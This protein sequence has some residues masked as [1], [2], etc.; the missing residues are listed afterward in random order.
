MKPAWPTSLAV[1]EG[2]VGAL[3]SRWMSAIM[4]LT[5]A[6]VTATIGLANAT[7][8]S[9][10]A[11]AER[12]WIDAGGYVFVVEPS[13]DSD[14]ALDV[15]ACERLSSV[16]GVGGSFAVTLTDLAAS[17]SH[18]PGSTASVARVSPGI[19]QFFDVKPEA[20]GADVIVTPGVNGQTAMVAG[21]S[22]VMTI[23]AFDGTRARQSVLAS[24][25]AID[26]PILAESI[27]GAYLIG[28]LLRGEADQCYVATDAAH[29][30]TVR[31]YI[32]SALGAQGPALVRPRLSENTYGVDFATAY[33]TRPLGWAWCVGALALLTPWALLRYSRRTA[34][35]VYATFGVHARARLTMQ[36]TEWTVV[37]GV[38]AAWGWAIATTFAVGLGADIGIALQQ[39]TLQAAAAWCAASVG[40]VIIGLLPVGTLLDVLKERT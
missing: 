7:D 16:D 30:E 25:T 4:V 12:E 31:T 18:A 32:A 35:A 13:P 10:L 5:T 28:D 17:P 3:T 9:A 15:T 40:A 2:F 20:A 39:I 23:E 1:R 38:G 11:A 29:V 6:G 36:M 37:T 8:V 22:T 27:A 33:N 21:E 19:Y 26:S 34:T 24:V 14:L